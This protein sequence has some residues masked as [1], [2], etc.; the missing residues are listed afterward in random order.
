MLR[1][2]LAVSYP[3]PGALTLE[4]TSFRWKV[5]PSLDSPRTC[6][7]T[8]NMPQRKSYFVPPYLHERSP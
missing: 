1:E 6:L 3:N 4:A 8:T 7:A 2:R 5:V